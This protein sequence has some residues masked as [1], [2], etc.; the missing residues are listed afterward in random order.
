MPLMQVLEQIAKLKYKKSSRITRES[1]LLLGFLLVLNHLLHPPH[2]SDAIQKPCKLSMCPHLKNTRTVKTH[3]DALV[4]VLRK[5]ICVH[6][7]KLTWL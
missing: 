1:H 5:S 3:I 6:S 7:T 2:G 4:M